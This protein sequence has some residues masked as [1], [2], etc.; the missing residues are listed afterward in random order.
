MTTGGP[1][2]SIFRYSNEGSGELNQIQY[3]ELAYFLWVL[4]IAIMVI[5]FLNFLVSTIGILYQIF[6]ALFLIT[7]IASS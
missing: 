1:D 3:P 5:L 2:D 6:F 4:F 7:N